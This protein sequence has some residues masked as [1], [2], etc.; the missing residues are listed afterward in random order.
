[1]FDVFVTEATFWAYVLYFMNWNPLVLLS[2]PYKNHS[3]AYSEALHMQF[4]TLRKGDIAIPY[5][6]VYR[7]DILESYAVNSHR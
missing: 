7:T 2:I 1:M 5:K 6:A 4:C 3:V